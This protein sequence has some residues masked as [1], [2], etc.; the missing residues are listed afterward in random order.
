M[1]SSPPARARWGLDALNFFLADVQ[2]G[3]GPY[4]AIYLLAV[5]GPD[6]GWNQA[7]I[8]LVMTIAG[9]VGHPRTDPCGRTD[10]P[11]PAQARRHHRRR[12][13]GDG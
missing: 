1:P 11:Q 8:G 10:R 4:L 9:I 3:L 13:R 6:Q 12:H 5:R 7:T 2:D